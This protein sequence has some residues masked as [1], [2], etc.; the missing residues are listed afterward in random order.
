MKIKDIFLQIYDIIYEKMRIFN[1]DIEKKISHIIK[2]Q[3]KC[4]NLITKDEFNDQQNFL[5]F[6]SEKIDEIEE[7]IKNLEKNIKNKDFYTNLPK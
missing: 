6:I 4:M 3:F 5:V 2:S 1:K 7:R